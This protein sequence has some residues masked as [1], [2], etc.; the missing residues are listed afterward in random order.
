MTGYAARH[1]VC[2]AYLF[3]YIPERD[4]LHQGEYERSLLRSLL[5][6]GESLSLEHVVLFCCTAALRCRAA[7][8]VPPIPLAQGWITQEERAIWWRS[9]TRP[10][11][12][13]QPS[14]LRVMCHP[15]E[16]V[17]DSRLLTILSQSNRAEATL[18]DQGLFPAVHGERL[19]LWCCSCTPP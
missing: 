4:R 19:G 18:A 16:V 3:A 17:C 8:S 10:K 1:R 7:P 15:G 6:Y 12:A 11:E 13:R 14:S 9:R 5:S 2:I